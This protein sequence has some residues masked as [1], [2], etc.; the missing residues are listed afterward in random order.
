M[1][2]NQNIESRISNLDSFLPSTNAT[3]CRNSSHPS[4]ESPTNHINSATN[5]GFRLKYGGSAPAAIMSHDYSLRL[6]A[7]NRLKDLF[8]SKKTN[9]QSQLRRYMSK[10]VPPMTNKADRSL[11]NSRIVDSRGTKSA[12]NNGNPIDFLK[13]S[14]D[15]STGNPGDP[16]DFMLGEQNSYHD[17]NGDADDNL[18]VRS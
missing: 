13:H 7:K 3:G 1:D 16:D 15:S 8:E 18:S 9:V 17:L 2:N 10:T 14:P 12:P 6:S 5:Q 11:L 4:V